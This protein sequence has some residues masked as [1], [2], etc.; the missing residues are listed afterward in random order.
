MCNLYTLK[1]DLFGWAAE[2]EKLV[3]Q[4]LPLPAGAAEGTSNIDL[5]WKEQIYPD[6]RAP[7]LRTTPLGVEEVAF[8]RWG[9]PSP[10]FALRGRNADSGVTN[11]RNTASPHWRRWLSPS[12]RCLV[13]MTAFSEPDQVGGSKRPV[14]FELAHQPFAYFAGIWTN[15]T[16]VRKVKEGEINCDLFAFLTIDAH[17]LVAQ[18]HTKATPVILTTGEEADT[19][20]RAPWDEAQALQR[21]LPDGALKLLGTETYSP[22]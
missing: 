18:Y 21:T 6:Y 1:G 7:I 20:M 8:A 12:N 2:H 17:P 3:G 13:P 19:W 11:V 16:C 9:M 5:T 4:V 15:W 22:R 10:A 14:W